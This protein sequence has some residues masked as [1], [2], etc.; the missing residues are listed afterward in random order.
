MNLLIKGRASGKT[1]ELIYASEATQYPIV[2]FDRRSI[3]YIRNTAK[4]MR[5][6]IPEPLC[7]RDFIGNPEWVRG[8]KLPENILLD[9]AGM[10]IG[11]ALNAYLGTN[12]VAATMTDSLREHYDGMKKN[13]MEV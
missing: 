11:D 1:T 8:R 5:C 10:I 4:D 2:T 6:L 7:I 9:E 13:K 3:D 12:V